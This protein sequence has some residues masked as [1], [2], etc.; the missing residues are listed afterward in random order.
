MAV[1]KIVLKNFQCHKKLTLDLTHLVVSIVGGSDRGKSSIIR[2][3]RWLAT[4]RPGGSGIIRRDGGETENRTAVVHLRIDGRSIKRVRGPGRNSYRIDGRTLKAFGSGVPDEVENLLN[5]SSINFQLQHQPSFL[6]SLSPG[7][8]ARELNSVINLSEIDRVQ[9]RLA[10]D[11]RRARATAE[12]SETR[13]AEVRERRDASAWVQDSDA[14]LIEVELKYSTAETLQNR[15]ATLS[16]MLDRVSTLKEVDRKRQGAKT[17]L[18]GALAAGEKEQALR[19]RVTVLANLIEEV[20][21]VHAS[22]QQYTEQVDKLIARLEAVSTCPV[23][24]T[25]KKLRKIGKKIRE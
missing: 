15:V 23:C 1:E 9:S 12:V 7:E 25:P 13:L 20:D 19:E 24:G 5:M 17:T 14:D 22:V 16:E 4:N 21:G 11:L 10:S 2:A 3:L 18:A 8:V 6:F